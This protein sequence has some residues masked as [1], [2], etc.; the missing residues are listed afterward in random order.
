MLY[1]FDT[2]AL[3]RAYISGKL[4][5]RY[6]SVISR[7]KNAVFVAEISMLE[8]VSALGDDLRGGRITPQ[9]YYLADEAF[10]EDIAGGRIQVRPFL[11]S[12]YVQ[13]RYIL[14]HVGIDAKRNLGSQDAIVACTA[15]ELAIEK[16]TAVKLLT[17]DRRFANVV[18]DIKLFHGLVRAEYLAPN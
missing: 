5:K 15:R 14:A 12:Q 6:R 7:H 1:L 13:S 17:C 2:C 8:I 16:R 9:Q 10:L 11:A 3:K 4:Q 18:N